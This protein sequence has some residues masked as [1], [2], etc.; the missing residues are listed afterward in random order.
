MI[1]IP[2]EPDYQTLTFDVKDLATQRLR[3]E[4]EDARRMAVGMSL[5]GDF[6]MRVIR[7]HVPCVCGAGVCQ[8]HLAQREWD[9]ATEG[10][11]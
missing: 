6:L 8:V 5:A 7:K 9:K 1:R 10:K 2:P 3:K 4:L 11:L